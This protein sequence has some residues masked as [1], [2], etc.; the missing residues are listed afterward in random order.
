MSRK[1]GAIKDKQ[2]GETLVQ[3]I[4]PSNAT[5]ADSDAISKSLYFLSETLSR[6]MNHEGGGFLGGRFGYGADYENDVFLMHHFCWCE[7][8]DC[9]WCVGCRCPHDR[10]EVWLDGERVHESWHEVAERMFNVPLP[11]EVAKNGTPEYRAADKKFNAVMRERDRRLKHIYS[12]ITH[13]CQPAGMI[14]NRK[15]GKTS[16]PP[17]T[18]PNFWHKPTGFKVWWYKWIGRD[19]EVNKNK[20]KFEEWVSILRDCFKSLPRDLKWKS[21]KERAYERTP[22]YLQQ[23]EEQQNR[24]VEF[25]GWMMK[26]KQSNNRSTAHPEEP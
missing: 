7:K 6:G 21:G 14:E 18:A 4:G 19:M 2:T 1:I 5:Q 15:R 22:E 24:M 20:L 23:E 16:K 13:V 3:M 9:L 25:I 17:Q 11:W 8:D 12:A 10:D 26:E